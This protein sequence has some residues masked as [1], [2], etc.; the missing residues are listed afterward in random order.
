MEKREIKGRRLVRNIMVSTVLSLVIIPSLW[1]LVIPR[2]EITL[3]TIYH[4]VTGTGTVGMITVGIR[5]RNTG[6]RPVEDLR[7]SV[8][9]VNGTY[10]Y[11]GGFNGTATLGILASVEDSTTF[12]GSHYRDYIITVD[13]WAV[14]DGRERHWTLSHSVIE[15]KHPEMNIEWTDVL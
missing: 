3:T 1:F 9:V 12:A 4:E 11:K 15:A 13:I 8:T 2:E 6:S 7:Y 14:I 10:V 5:I